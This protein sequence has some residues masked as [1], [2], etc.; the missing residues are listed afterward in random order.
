MRKKEKNTK[1]YNQLWFNADLKRCRGRSWQNTA[2]RAHRVAQ[3]STSRAL[4]HCTDVT[5]VTVAV[6]ISR[7]SDLYGG[8]EELNLQRKGKKLLHS[9]N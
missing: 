8:Y 7:C 4:R 3:C 6:V 5:K 2:S 1:T 9:I